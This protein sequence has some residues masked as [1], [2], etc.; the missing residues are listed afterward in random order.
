MVNHAQRIFAALPPPPRAWPRPG[1]ASG[2]RVLVVTSAV[3]GSACACAGDWRRPRSSP[4]AETSGRRPR[5]RCPHRRG[6]RQ[7]P[8]GT[9][10]PRP[11][12]SISPLRTAAES[13]KVAFLER[14]QA[15]I[16]LPSGGTAP[17]ELARATRSSS[18]RTSPD[19]VMWSVVR[20]V[21]TPPHSP[22]GPRRR[23]P[24]GGQDEP[25]SSAAAWKRASSPC[26]DDVD[27]RVAPRPLGAAPAGHGSS[28]RAASHGLR[29]RGPHCPIGVAERGG[30]CAGSP[31]APLRLP[32]G[33]TSSLPATPGPSGFS[34][35]SRNLPPAGE[36]EVG[37]DFLNVERVA[38][39]SCTSR[40]R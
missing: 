12:H 11:T 34:P 21:S 8:R 25:R 30:T 2:K 38:K 14:Q 28:P 18:P 5:L 6:P 4:P 13:A 16:A 40:L 3:A 26:H 23:A 29:L 17:V 10:H 20:E 22:P 37:D 35:S 33:K 36:N 1:M 27:A 32:A 31:S 24:R 19:R 7:R 39:S 15:D 9:R